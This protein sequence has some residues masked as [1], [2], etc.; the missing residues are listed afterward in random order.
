VAGEQPIELSAGYSG[1]SIM[2]RARSAVL[3]WLEPLGGRGVKDQ[4]V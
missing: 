1:V 3:A 2:R 4:N